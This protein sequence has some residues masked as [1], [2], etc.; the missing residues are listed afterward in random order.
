MARQQ[1]LF[2][3]SATPGQGPARGLTVRAQPDRPLTKTQKAFNR[4][5]AKVEQLRT[6]LVADTQLFEEALIY[7]AQHLRHRIQQVVS[8]RTD[9]VQALAPFLDDRRLKKGDTRVLREILMSQLDEILAHAEAIDDDLRALFERLHG[10]DMK[11]V[12]EEQLQDAR[13]AMEAMFADMGIEVN[14]S[15]FRLGM[16][17]TD[18]AAKAAELIDELKRQ[19]TE[20]EARA[21]PNR[22]KTKRE[23]REEE[24]LRRAEDARKVSIG[25]I[26]RQLAKVLHPDLEKDPDSRQRKSALMQELTA[27]YARQDLHALLRLQLEWIHRE[28]GD[29]ARLTDERLDAYNLVLKEQVAQLER[30]LT[31]LPLHPKFHPLI[32]D[33]GPWGARVRTD[34]PAEARRLDA[35]A[36]GLRGALDSLQAPLAL[37]HVRELIRE[38]RAAD[39]AR[40]KLRM[41]TSRPPWLSTRLHTHPHSPSSPRPRPNR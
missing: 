17:E 18:V 32:E 23:Q 16:T 20:A 11:D 40:P 12:E 14:L 9:V 27:A 8:A 41:P 6:R 35:V 29:T 37:T 22:R 4:L 13:S 19:A 3:K 31:E 26:Y 30:E 36:D 5:V 15:G 7:H 24:R 25:S 21:N 39:K 34:G 2:D 28:E 38:Q 10:S 33:L 1:P